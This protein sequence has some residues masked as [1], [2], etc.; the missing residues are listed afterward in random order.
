MTLI[1]LTFNLTLKNSI[2]TIPSQDVDFTDEGGME[3]LPQLIS[4]L[5][6][7]E[8]KDLPSWIK[9]EIKITK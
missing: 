2:I 6:E 9:N 4:K 5:I 1:Q 8:E 7:K 3:N